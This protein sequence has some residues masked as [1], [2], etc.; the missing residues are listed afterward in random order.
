MSR[1]PPAPNALTIDVEDYFHVENLRGVA[2]TELWDFFE[3]RVARNVDRLLALLARADARATFFVLGWVAE[4]EPAAVRRIVDAGHEVA[5][6]GYGHELVHGL[7]PGRFREDVRR[8]RAATEDVAGTRL[9]GY[10]APTWSV[11]KESLWALDI[12]REEGFVYDSSIFP[13]MHDR[14]GIPDAPVH[15]H[16]IEPGRPGAGLFEFPP[17]TMTIFGQNL[18]LGGGGYLRLLPAQLFALAIRRMNA[19]GHPAAIYLHPWEIDP[20]QPRLH[21]P[22]VSYFRHYNGLARCEAKLA[23]LLGKFRFATMREALGIGADG[24]PAPEAPPRAA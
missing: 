9:L 10:R 24:L 6:H 4:R 1:E 11:T 7:G 16:R 22:L 8:A 23:W 2:R 12:L 17:L 21:V 20:G 14:Y 5:S 13:V 18:P 3:R 19:T 15:P